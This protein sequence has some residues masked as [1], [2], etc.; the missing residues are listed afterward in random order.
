M[1]EKAEPKYTVKIAQGGQKFFYRDGKL[2]RKAQVPKEELVKLQQELAA[3]GIETVDVNE[4]ET[5]VLEPE[6][7]EAEC[8]ICGEPANRRRF[9]NL[10]TVAVCET[11]YFETTLGKLVIALR[12]KGQYEPVLP[13]Q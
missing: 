9:V 5:A 6:H 13:N 12:E 8:L 4:P 10:Q 1:D 3:Q 11:H 2:I 7:V